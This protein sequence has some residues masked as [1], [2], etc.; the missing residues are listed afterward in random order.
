MDHN[1]IPAHLPTIEPP[2]PGPLPV[3][4]DFTKASTAAAQSGCEAQP[5]EL[6]A[7]AWYLLRRLQGYRGRP[8]FDCPG[9]HNVDEVTVDWLERVASPAEWAWL[10]ENFDCT[11]YGWPT[12]SLLEALL[13]ARS[14]GEM[15]QCEPPAVPELG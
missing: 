1:G 7:L 11:R 15:R 2:A 12:V 13:R 6:T 3:S 5:A 9:S 4:R 14:A 10:A 8:V